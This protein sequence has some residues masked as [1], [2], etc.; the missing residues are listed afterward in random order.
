MIQRMHMAWRFTEKR[1]LLQRLVKKNEMQAKPHVI[2]IIDVS[3]KVSVTL[4]VGM[5]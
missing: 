3:R 4:R 2:A 5:S 1:A